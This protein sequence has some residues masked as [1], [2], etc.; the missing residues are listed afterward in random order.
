[1]SVRRANSA[2]YLR[3]SAC[4]KLT[5][6]SSWGRV[7]NC[8]IRLFAALKRRLIT[9]EGSAK[10]VHIWAFEKL[11]IAR[12]RAPPGLPA[13]GSFCDVSDLYQRCR[14]APEARH[15]LMLSIAA[16]CHRLVAASGVSPGT[17]CCYRPGTVCCYRPVYSSARPTSLN[18]VALSPCSTAALASEYT[19]LPTCRRRRRLAVAE[20]RLPRDRAARFLAVFA[21]STEDAAAATAEGGA[22]EVVPIKPPEEWDLAGLKAEALRQAERAKKKVG[23]AATQLRQAREEIGVLMDQKDASLDDLEACPDVVTIESHVDELRVRALALN[24]LNDALRAV[25]SKADPEFPRLVA[26][27]IQLNICDTP[28]LKAPRGPKK[29]KGEPTKP[30]VP[31]F[32]YTSDDGI[33]IRVGRRSEDNDELS[34]NPEHRDNAD[35]WMHAAGCPGSHV[36]IRFTGPDLPRETLADAAALTVTNSKAAQSGKTGVTLVRCRQVSKPKGAKAGLVQLSG[37]IRSLTVNVKNETERLTRLGV[38]KR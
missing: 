11:M 10:L 25:K 31:Y 35:W 3:A 23:K 6:Q 4:V 27:A 18:W 32:T 2:Y 34:C 9:E 29:P 7:G 13:G 28:P 5:H 22:A 24:N 19:P 33:D 12:A 26:V 38:T 8:G 37:D 21:S 20:P 17:V 36:V 16:R 15:F 30:R 14:G 1:M